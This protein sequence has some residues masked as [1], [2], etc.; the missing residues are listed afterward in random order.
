MYTSCVTNHLQHTHKLGIIII[1]FLVAV[2]RENPQTR[3]LCEKLGIKNPWFE[4]PLV[5]V[6]N[7]D[8]ITL[9]DDDEDDHTSSNCIINCNISNY[10]EEIKL[11]S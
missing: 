4:I 5:T 10:V 8:E 3:V 1:L 11:R 6:I 2:N 7:P 9:T